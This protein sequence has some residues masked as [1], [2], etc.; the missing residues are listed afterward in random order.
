M[1][2]WCS[3]TG[4]EYSKYL[5]KKK[6]VPMSLCAPQNSHLFAPGSNTDYAVKSKINRN[7]I[8]S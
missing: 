5:E 2:H 1:E 7:Y 6:T 8:Y 3:D 4:K